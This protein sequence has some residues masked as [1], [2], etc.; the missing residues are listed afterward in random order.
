M[1]RIGVVDLAIGGWTAGTV[2]ARTMFLSL[3][4]AG[5][6]VRFLTGQSEDLPPGGVVVDRPRYWPGEWTLR[7]VTR[8]G[9]RN[10]IA[11]Q[12]IASGID[13]VLPVVEPV[14]YAGRLG[15][16][17][18]IPDFQHLHLKEYYDQSQREH[19]DRRFAKLAAQSGLMLFS[20]QDAAANFTEHYPSHASK[21]RVASFPS[22]FAL[23]GCRASHAEVL[24]RYRIP[25]RFLLVANQFWQHKNHQVVVEALTLLRS[26]GVSLPLVV[27]G[28]PADY[29]DRRNQVLSRALQTAAA[30]G[31][32]DQTLFL[33]QVSRE[34]LEGLLRSATAIIQPSRYE[35]WNTTVEDA[36]AL[37][38]PLFLSNLPVHREQCPDAIGFFGLDAPEELA[39]LLAAHW[40]RLPARPDRDGEVAAM[41]RASA[42]AVMYGRRLQA[43][44]SELI[45]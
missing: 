21:A 14:H 1:S 41:E 32:W 18:W 39:S 28:M 31:I 19:L 36:K 27:V 37:G 6:D 11:A 26:R 5:A 8:L 17:G 33:G 38:C 40:D 12:A 7:S 44:C 20:S 16:V 29:R 35:G 24:D 22:I 4:K 13:V 25:P 23:E 9:P 34:E 3:Q 30:G 42:A 2:V 10:A 45:R 43:I 15:T